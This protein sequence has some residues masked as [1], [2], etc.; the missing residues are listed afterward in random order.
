MLGGHLG[1]LSAFARET[2]QG[3]QGE[4]LLVGRDAVA[5]RYKKWSSKDPSMETARALVTF[6]WLLSEEQEKKVQS[7]VQKLLSTKVDAVASQPS[8]KRSHAAKSSSSNNKKRKMEPTHES[9][10]RFFA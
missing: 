6:A 7:G 3:P 10:D 5:E 8:K 2:I 1:R 9:A 4:V